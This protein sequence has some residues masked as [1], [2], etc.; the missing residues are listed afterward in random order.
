MNKAETPSDYFSDLHSI[1]AIGLSPALVGIIL[2]VYT[3]WY[4]AVPALKKQNTT[5]QPPIVGYR[6]LWEPTWLVRLRF[7]RGSRR[8]IGEGYEQFKDTMFKVRRVGTDV[9]LVS[10]KYMDEIR[11]LTRDATGSVPPLVQDY[12]G[13]YTHGMPFLRSDLQNRVL[14]QKLT[15]NLPSLVPVMIEE[16]KFAMQMEMPKCADE[17][18][19]IDIMPILSRI[20]TRITSRIFLGPKEGRNEEWLRATVEYTKNLFLTGMALRFFPRFLRPLVAPLLPSYHH[21][22]QNV[23]TSRRIV[24]EIVRERREIE[25]AKPAGY[26]K[27]ADILQWMMDAATGQEAEP[28]DLAQRMLILSVTSIHTT[29]LTMTQAIYD[30]CAHPEYLA[31]LRAEV[32]DVLHA[33]GGWGKLTVNHLRKMDSLLKESQRFNPVFLLTFNRILPK[34]ITLSNGVSIPVGSRIAVPSNAMLN[35]PSRVPGDGSTSFDAFRYSRLREEPENAQR[36]LFVMT[37]HNNL[38]FGYGKFACPGRFYAANEMKMMLA[39]MLICYDMR[40]PDGCGRPRNFTIDS[41]MYPDPATRLLIRKRSGVE[42][43]MEELLT[44]VACM[45]V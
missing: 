40:F 45:A 17:W 39:H 9:L 13:E 11:T 3:L 23:A 42:E 24:G 43:G 44:S 35:D 10:S 8:I 22:W 37:D 7:I 38:A 26:A 29:T 41:D 21:L 32:V 12:P 27:P 4:L 14:Q 15:P 20:I 34:S 5:G 33:E 16:L 2:G 6:S 31:P 30:L 25:A 36:H 18:T 28:E 19:T 1:A